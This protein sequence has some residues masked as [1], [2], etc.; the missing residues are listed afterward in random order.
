MGVYARDSRYWWMALEGTPIRRSTRVPIGVG[1]ARK[2]SRDEAEA[3]YRAAMGDLA[4]GRFKLPTKAPA[5]TFRQHATWYVEHVTTTHRSIA[6]ERSAI[7]GLSA[8]FADT[9]LS[10]ITTAQVEGW[11]LT[12]AKQVKQSTVNRELEVLKPLLGSAVPLYMETNPARAVR[13]FRLRF[14]PIALLSPEAEAAILTHASPVERAFV[15][16][17]LDALLRL[18]DVR[19]L[20]TEHDRGTY[21][22]IVDPKVEAYK[23]PV[24]TRLRTA[25]DALAPKGGYYFPRKYAGTWHAI[26][27]ATAHDLFVALCRRADVPVGRAAGGVTYHSLRHTGATRAAR[28][29]KLTVVQRLGGWKTLT[30]LARYDHPDDAEMVRAAEAIGDARPVHGAG[31]TRE[32]RPKIGGL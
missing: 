32:N 13:K 26:S 5:R 27:P 6:R 9:P 12:R 7:L 18:S 22:E 28:S 10:A 16:L 23:V 8:Y 24:S 11:K 31:A 21:L 25:L 19:R 20:R 15:L 2:T 29:V 17:G 14:P 3:I 4:R 30:Q 1:A